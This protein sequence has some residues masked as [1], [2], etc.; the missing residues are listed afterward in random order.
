[1]KIDFILSESILAPRKLKGSIQSGKWQLVHGTHFFAFPEELD[2]YSL[3]T[4]QAH[5]V[6]R[7]GRERLTI[8]QKFICIS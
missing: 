4:S 1:M 2:Q 3:N 8:D 5:T 6:G 7:S